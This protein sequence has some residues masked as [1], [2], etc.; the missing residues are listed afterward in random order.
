VDLKT[1]ELQ[2]DG[3][4][5][6]LTVLPRQNQTEGEEEEDETRDESSDE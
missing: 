2:E 3:G 6:S 5:K 1:E 4:K